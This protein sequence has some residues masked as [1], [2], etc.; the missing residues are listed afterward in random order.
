M[1]NIKIIIDRIKNSPLLTEKQKEHWLALAKN[2]AS[3]QAEEFLVILDDFEK[4]YKNLQDMNK[5][6]REAGRAKIYQKYYD[7]LLK[8]ERVDMRQ[9]W[10]EAEKKSDKNE[11]KKMD[12][13]LKDL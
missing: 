3:E 8:F 5:K 7:D 12:N 11:R 13:L 9:A 4:Q 2:F 6:E 10:L 1:T